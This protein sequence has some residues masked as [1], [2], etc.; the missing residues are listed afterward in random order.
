MDFLSDVFPLRRVRKVVAKFSRLN[1]RKSRFGGPRLTFRSRCEAFSFFRVP[2]DVR[3]LVRLLHARGGRALSGTHVAVQI[4][5]KAASSVPIAWH[6]PQNKTT[7]IA[8]IS[9]RSYD[10]DTVLACRRFEIRRYLPNASKTT[11]KQRDR[12]SPAKKGRGGK[13]RENSKVGFWF[14]FQVFNFWELPKS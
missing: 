6:T 12:R 11:W 2:A 8:S 9:S 13:E 14:C 4:I 1:R 3:S 7:L 10:T 5:L